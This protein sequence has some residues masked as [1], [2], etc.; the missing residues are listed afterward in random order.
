[1]VEQNGACVF[2]TLDA[3]DGVR[4]G[5]VGVGGMGG[6]HA[7]T[8]HAL[9][10]VAVTAVSDPLHANSAA[11]Q[12]RIGAAIVDDP[13]ELVASDDV[14]A[15]VIASPDDTH[16]EYSLAALRRGLPTLCEKPLATSAADG[17]R[18]VDAESAAGRR[19]VR[20]GFMREHDQAHVQLRSALEEL[21]TVE[22]V[23]AVHRNANRTRRPLDE[24]VCQSMVH[25]IHT[26]RHLTGAEIVWVRASGSGPSDGSFR[27]VVA[28]CGLSSGSHAVL[29]F[30]D[31]GF[32]YEVGVEVLTDDG[33]A[34]TGRPLRSVTRRE[35]SIEVHL[36]SDWF[37]W[38]AD[39]YRR[40][41]QAWI[42]SIRT[43][44]TDGPSVWDGYAAQL[45]VDATLRSLAI[46]ETV[47]IETPERPSLYG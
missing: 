41:D 36:G 22:Y 29:E 40:Q 26:V 32:A 37:G 30:D 14:D 44:G 27:H 17:R 24:I 15:V 6:F 11:V 3:M 43:G 34:V 13:F 16:V 28:L 20:L 46:G 45:V 7:D 31:G 5:I 12:E 10:G 9:A 35:G 42:D 38:F 18:V 25:D 19:L 1:M 33:D 4:V 23:R 47:S 8:L 39:A 21:G 2:G